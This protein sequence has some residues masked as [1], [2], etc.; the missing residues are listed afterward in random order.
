MRTKRYARSVIT[1]A[2]L[3]ER[4]RSRGFRSQKALAEALEVSPRLVWD[5]EHSEVGVD[6]EL[7][8]RR[9]LWPEPPNIRDF[10]DWELLIEIARRLAEDKEAQPNRDT[11]TSEKV[12]SAPRVTDV[13]PRPGRHTGRSGGRP[14]SPDDVE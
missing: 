10:D 7:A 8:V 2:E 14:K 12:Q 5:W 6:Y 4:R 9:L 13:N 1:G 3:R 11:S